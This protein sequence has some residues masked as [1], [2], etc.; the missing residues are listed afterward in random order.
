MEKIELIKKDIEKQN[1]EKAE[2]SLR[3]L[4]LKDKNNYHYQLLTC[5]YVNVRLHL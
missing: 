3:E 2:R 5:N 1:Y 4:I